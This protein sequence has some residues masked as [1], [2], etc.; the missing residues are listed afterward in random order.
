MILSGVRCPR[1]KGPVDAFTRRVRDPHSPDGWSDARYMRVFRSDYPISPDDRKVTRVVETGP[2][3]GETVVEYE[4][5]WAGYCKPCSAGW[6]ERELEKGEPMRAAGLQRT[7]AGEASRS[8][9]QAQVA[10]G[11]DGGSDGRAADKR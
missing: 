6:T 8:L 7:A 5:V 9:A 10:A 3:K 4:H 2:G 1:C 11:I